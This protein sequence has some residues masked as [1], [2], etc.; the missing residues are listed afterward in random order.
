MYVCIYIIYISILYIYAC[1]Y[2]LYIYIS[3]LYIYI[4]YI[5][6]ICMYSKINKTTFFYIST[7]YLLRKLSSYSYKYIYKIYIFI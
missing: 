3:I 7:N 5:Y 1:M 4:I 2:I 6:Y